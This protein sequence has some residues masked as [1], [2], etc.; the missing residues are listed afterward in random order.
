MKIEF[1]KTMGFALCRLLNRVHDG[2]VVLVWKDGPDFRFTFHDEPPR[3]AP[4]RNWVC[5]GELTWHVEGDRFAYELLAL[6]ERSEAELLE[7][8][9]QTAEHK[10]Y[11]EELWRRYSLRERLADLG[12][13]LAQARKDRGELPGFMKARKGA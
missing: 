13:T 6:R 7:R 10:A 5:I 8:A 1:P 2:Q 3:F 11:R 12:K 9:R 4:G